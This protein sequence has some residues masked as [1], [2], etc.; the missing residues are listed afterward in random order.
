[1]EELAG[2]G[3]KLDENMRRYLS[4]RNWDLG[5]SMRNP[6][7]AYIGWGVARIRTEPDDVRYGQARIM[8]FQRALADAKGE[9]VR[10]RQLE[11]TTTM[12]RRYIHDDAFPA[13]RRDIDQKAQFQERLSIFAEKALDLSE[14][15]LNR[16]LQEAGVDPGEYREMDRG[17]RK[18][19]LH[20]A[21]ALRSTTQA[22]A[23]LRGL[24][25]LTTFQDLNSVGV[26]VIHNDQSELLGRQIFLGDA[27]SR[28][29]SDVVAATIRE[30]LASSCPDDTDYIHMHGVRIMEDETGEKVVVS[31]GQWSPPITRGMSRRMQ[32]THFESAGRMAMSR[33]EAELTDFVNS[34]LELE[35]ASDIA[36]IEEITRL[37][38]QG[39]VE[40]LESYEIGARIDDIVQQYGRARLEGVT[41]IKQ[42]AVNDPKTGHVIVGH[43]AMWSPS[44]RD[45]ALGRIS[46]EEVEPGKVEYD[47]KVIEA[48]ALDHLDPTLR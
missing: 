13:A 44:A 24:R 39:R 47:D 40:E 38:T 33:A 12:R 27:V 15:H 18:T 31:F 30:Q 28:R 9:F 26:L 5:F 16:L 46:E 25:V 8:A 3:A 45:A 35:S 42:W 1:M 23:S 21:I 2:A 48:P 36:E 34:T 7:N 11:N 20:D 43:V 4:D 41:T 32:E 29:S 14:A 22:V 10:W 17:E 19:V 6:G 37:T